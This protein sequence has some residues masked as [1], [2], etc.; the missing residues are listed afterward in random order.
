MAVGVLKDGGCNINTASK[1]FVKSHIHYFKIVE[2]EIEINPSK[3]NSSEKSLR[4]SSDDTVESDSP[5]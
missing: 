3:K 1:Y 4:E 2:S 5:S